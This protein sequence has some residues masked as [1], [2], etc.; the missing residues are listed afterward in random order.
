MAS[1]SAA[2]RRTSDWALF[3]DLPEGEGTR[4]RVAGSPEKPR[5][6]QREREH[7]DPGNAAL[8][9]VVGVGERAADEGIAEKRQQHQA[10]ER[11][12]HAIAPPPGEPKDGNEGG[13]A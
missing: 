11:D 3:I 6:S 5:A 12:A 7:G 1:A 9:A 2:K 8:V 13:A 4:I 10:R